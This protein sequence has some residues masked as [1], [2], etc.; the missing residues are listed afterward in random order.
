ML[1]V[2]LIASLAACGPTAGATVAAKP[3]E[4][5]QTVSDS[6][7]F[8]GTVEEFAVDDKGQTVLMMRRA[9]GS[10]FLKTLKVTITAA[11]KFGAEDEN[12][13]NGAFLEVYYGGTV[14]AGDSVDAI[15]INNL[16]TEEDSNFNGK[17]VSVTKS[18]D[19]E[20]SGQ[21]LLDPLEEGAMQFAFNYDDSTQLNLDIDKLEPGTLLNVL[22]SP[23]ATRSIP[24]QS[25]AMEISIYQP[26]EEGELP[27]KLPDTSAK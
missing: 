14:N 13:G 21:L 5:N 6:S 2:L 17:L 27:V 22:H 10:S 25:A 16:M 12:L 19:K 23:A 8:I 1:S 18:T 4:T 11:T 26:P 7:R 15:T 20:G 9:V 3:N 24:P